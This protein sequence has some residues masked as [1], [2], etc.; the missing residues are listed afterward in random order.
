MDW[1]NVRWSREK[2]MS[3]RSYRLYTLRSDG[4][5]TGATSRSFTDDAE[6]VIHAWRLL[7]HHAGVEIWQTDRLVDH[8]SGGEGAADSERETSSSAAA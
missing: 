8:L 2:Y 7:D 5:I 3:D 1:R 6:A 4:G